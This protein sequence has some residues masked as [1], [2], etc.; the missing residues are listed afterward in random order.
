VEA[1]GKPWVVAPLYNLPAEPEQ[2]P[3]PE[4]LPPSPYPQGRASEPV[5]KRRSTL[6]ATEKV[7]VGIDVCKARLDVALLP[8]GETFT[9][10]N[11][12]DGIQT[13]V[14]KLLEADP[15]LVVLEATGGL[16]RPLVAAL[17]ASR[18]ASAVVNPRQSRDFAKAIGRLAKTD[19][20]D[21]LVLARFAEA[22][23]PEP[24]APPEAEAME[25]QAIL[26]RRRQLVQMMTAEKNRLGASASGKVRSRLEAHIRWLE[27][28]LARTDRDLGE[29]IE[30]SP[31]FKENETLLRSV[32]GVGPVLCRTL[33][34]ELPELGSLSSR[35]LSALVGVA[36]INRDSGAFRGR[37]GVWGG[38]ARVREALYMGALVATRYNPAIKEFYERLVAAGK[39]KKVALVACMRKLLVILNAVTRDRT[40]WR[41]PHALNS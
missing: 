14:E 13:L 20:I 4:I 29:A 3:G 36:P 12:E 7:H 27:K 26:A 18:L 15:V 33:L 6:N 24:K 41:C 34:A 25:F 16:Q 8:S 40:P 32:P 2:L 9:V 28:E 17:A 11:D 38:R 21:A 37:R 23:R 22:V 10:A 39:P 1:A 30:E 5:E 31:T 19:K 35:E